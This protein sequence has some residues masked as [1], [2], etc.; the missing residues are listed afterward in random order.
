MSHP[1]DRVQLM[2]YYEEVLAQSARN[3]GFTQDK[4][5]EQRYRTIEPESDKLLK[6]SIKTCSKED[7]E[8]FELM[9]K[10]NQEMVEMEYRSIE[11]VNSGKAN[12]V[13]SLLESEE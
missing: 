7:L 2:R 8:F 3:Y 12:D 11:L 5:W 1:L 9:D 6:E 13:I 10:T 4:K